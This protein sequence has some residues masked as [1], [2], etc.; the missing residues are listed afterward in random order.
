[1]GIVF[2]LLFIIDCACIIGYII[3]SFSGNNRRSNMLETLSYIIMGL[4]L[5]I[6]VLSNKGFIAW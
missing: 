1:M 3:S 4:L 2:W 6:A 5:V